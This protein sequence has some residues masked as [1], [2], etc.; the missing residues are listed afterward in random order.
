MLPSPPVVVLVEP[1]NPAN[2]GFVARAL[3]NFGLGEA[4]LLGGCGWK[5]TEA[6]R[7]GAPARER[8]Q[9]FQQVSDWEAATQGCT[10]L[11]GFTARSGRGRAP[12]SL[13][14]W[15]ERLKS[16]GAN[17]QLGLVFGREDRGLENEEAERCHTLV[18]IPT[19][20]LGSL[21]LSHAVAVAGYAWRRWAGGSSMPTPPGTGPSDP[22]SAG[23]AISDQADRIRVAA[24]AAE[25]LQ[26]AEFRDPAERIEATLRRLS[27]L[28][29]EARDLRIV[30]RALKHARW[31]RES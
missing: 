7:T 29:I 5:E 15:E 16:F 23:N 19:A 21:N 17:Q 22:E 30:E 24:R 12:I 4:R 11:I 28:P 1:Q 13:D 6:E 9:A 3:E 25:E 26:A 31:R 20:G 27:A 14:D 10:H 8:L 2:L 18:S